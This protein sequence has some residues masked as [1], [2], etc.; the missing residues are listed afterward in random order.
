VVNSPIGPK[1]TESIENTVEELDEIM[2]NLDL[3]KSLGY[4]D[5][6][7]SKSFDNYLEKDLTTRSGGVSD[8]S[9]DTW[10]PEGKCTN[11]IHQM[12]VVISEAAEDD[13]GGNDPVINSQGD[14]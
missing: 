7:S 4:S 5:K 10:R 9:E 6:G 1:P 3:G 11:S 13:D 2:E 8:S 14:N 12:C